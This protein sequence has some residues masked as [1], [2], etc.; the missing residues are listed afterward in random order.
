M[1]HLS[2]SLNKKNMLL[3]VFLFCLFVCLFGFFFFFFFFGVFFDTYIGYLY[4]AEDYYSHMHGSGMKGFDHMSA[5]DLRDGEK[6]ADNYTG[7][8]SAFIFTD[9]AQQLIKQ[10]NTSKVTIA[11]NIF[12]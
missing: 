11:L 12:H 4:A 2:K 5:L 9:R 7:Q 3:F 1:L 6:K 8:Y 10:H